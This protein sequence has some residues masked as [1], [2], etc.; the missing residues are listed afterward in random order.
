L[1]LDGRKSDSRHVD[2]RKARVLRTA[3]LNAPVRDITA[4]TEGITA[5]HYGVRLVDRRWKAS[6]RS[7]APTNRTAHIVCVSKSD[8]RKQRLGPKYGCGPHV[9]PQP[10][11]PPVSGIFPK[12]NLNV[13]PRPHPRRG[14]KSSP[15]A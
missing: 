8:R 6:P 1:S 3:R 2:P 12:Q 9:A 10:T 4:A 11:T 14:E 13:S 7:F 15:A 5:T